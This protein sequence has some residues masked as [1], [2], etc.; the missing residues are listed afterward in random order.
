[1]TRQRQKLRPCSSARFWQGCE[2]YFNPEIAG[3]VGLSDVYGISAF[4]NGEITRVGLPEPTP[5]V[6]R[7]WIQQTFGFGG[8]QEKLES[9]PNQLAEYKDYSRLTIA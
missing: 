2:V 8:E 3:G 4:P 7:L 9:G 6:A 1:M 5:Y